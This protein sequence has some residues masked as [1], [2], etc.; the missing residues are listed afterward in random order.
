MKFI[1]LLII[2]LLGWS[3]YNL[4]SKKKHFL[5]II[6]FSFLIGL[7]TLTILMFYLNILGIK[8]SSTS[9]LIVSVLSVFGTNYKFFIKPKKELEKIK[10]INVKELFFIG[11]INVVWIVCVAA[12]IFLLFV[13]TKKSLFWTTTAHDAITSFDLYAKAIAHEGKLINSLILEKSVGFGV[14]YPPLYS[15]ALSYTYMLG[16]ETSKI[17]PALIFIS[18]VISFYSL[19][20]KNSNATLAIFV[21]LILIISPEIIAQSAINT[22][23][24]PNAVLASLGIILLITWYN[25]NDKSYFLLSIIFLI[26]NVWTRSEGIIYVAGTIVLL[27]LFDKKRISYKYKIIYAV[28]TILPFVVWQIFLKINHDV[29]DSFVQVKYIYT[30]VLNLKQIIYIVK[31]IFLNLLQRAYFGLSAYIFV[32]IL[33][34]NII[35]IIKKRENLFLLCIIIVSLFLYMVLLNQLELRHDNLTNILKHSA[36][37]FVFTTI[38]LMWAYVSTSKIV[39]ELFNKIEKK[40]SFKVQ[41]NS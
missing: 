33:A 30:P 2:F 16:F 20:S 34:I 9:L 29:M 18:F 11:N 1:A 3:I 22:T 35:K 27:F 38:I 21:T 12:V 25:T 10:N 6:G 31:Y 4:V 17:I 26:L 40:L 39:V 15:F 36:K 32:V 41:T 24:V 19:I 13:I 28:L 23:S 8:L 14:A 7:G 5:E 37:R